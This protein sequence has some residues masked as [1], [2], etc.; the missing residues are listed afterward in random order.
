MMT[1]SQILS[2]LTVLAGFQVKHFLCDGPLQTKEMVVAKGY[3][4]QGLGVLH[5]A[6]HGIGTFIVF[7]LFSVSAAFCLGLAVLDFFIHYHVDYV[8]E[9]IVR[10]AGWTTSDSKFWWA[11]SADQMAHH[12]TYLGLVALAV[13]A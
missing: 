6:L 4:G 10:K 5:A 12:L 8:K 11:L 9:N 1:L 2:L 13:T 3:Y 7:W